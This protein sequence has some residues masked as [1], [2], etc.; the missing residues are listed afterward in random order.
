MD[1]FITLFAE[2]SLLT[3]LCLTVLIGGGIAAISGR[4]VAIT[5]RPR[6][7]LFFYMLL[8]SCVLRFFHWSLFEGTLLSLHYYAIDAA[9]L[10]IGAML[11]YQLSRMQ[12]IS[13]HYYWLK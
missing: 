13:T 7:Q 10:I 11:G 5:W 12:Q 8:L 3:F 1:Q 4:A 2:K 6:W 9:I